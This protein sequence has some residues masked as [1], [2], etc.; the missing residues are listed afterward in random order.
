MTT[1][2]VQIQNIDASSLQEM[3]TRLENQLTE[4]K[5]NYQPKEP[6]QWL[7][8]Y[9]VA[10]LF[11]ITLPTVHAWANKG[12]IKCYKIANKTRFKRSEIETA[13]TAIERRA[14]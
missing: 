13:L 3:F 11:K 8:R 1:T 9:E 6:T 5:E 4:I 10:E 2:N 12:L 7:T 14:Q